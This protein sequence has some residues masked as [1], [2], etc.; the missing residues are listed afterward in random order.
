MVC[1]LKQIISNSIFKFQDKNFPSNQQ[2]HKDG[3][4]LTAGFEFWKIFRGRVRSSF[5]NVTKYSLKSEFARPG[6]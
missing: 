3:G 5:A 2:K 6:D 1:F 4:I